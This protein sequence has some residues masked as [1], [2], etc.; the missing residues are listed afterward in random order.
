[1]TTTEDLSETGFCIDVYLLAQ[2]A[3]EEKGYESCILGKDD[4]RFIEYS[5]RS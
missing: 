3:G 2:E 1:M 5:L 4:L